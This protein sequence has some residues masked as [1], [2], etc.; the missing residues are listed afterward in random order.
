[1]K[2][3]FDTIV[4]ILFVLLLVYVIAGMNRTQTEK[5]LKRKNKEES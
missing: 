3:V 4:L 1:M 5:N 2:E